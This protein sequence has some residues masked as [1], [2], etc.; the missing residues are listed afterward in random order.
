MRI[1]W[2]TNVLMPEALMYLKGQKTHKGSGGWMHGLSDELC[3]MDDIKLFIATIT[4]LVSHLTRIQGESMVHYAIPLCGNDIKY[5]KKYE[6]TY[7]KIYQEVK[8]D[9]VH[10]HG[11]E[12]P[13][14]LAALRACGAKH[15]VISIQGLVSSISSYYL[16]GISLKDIALNPTLHD[17]LRPGLLKQK[18]EMVRRGEYEVQLFKEAEN[19]IGRTDWD[20]SQLK[21]RAP[22]VSYYN[23]DEILRKTFYEGDTWVYSQ[24][25]P[26]S[27]FL[28]SGGY[29]LKGLHKVLEAIPLVKRVFPDV[30]VRVAGDD[31]TY[32]NCN[33]KKRIKISTYG[34]IIKKMINKY[35]ISSNVSFSGPLTAEEMKLEYLRANVFICPSSIENS[36][37]SLCEAQVLGVP[38]LA[39]YVGGTPDLMRN[40]EEHLYRFE[41]VEVMSEKICQIFAQKE[42]MPHLKEIRQQA[43]K[44][45]NTKT[46][47]NDILN[48][49]K[50]VMQERQIKN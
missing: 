50:D 49:Y 31:I 8:P 39:S 32:S 44:R 35:D 33:I 30:T 24:C 38:V 1:L 5:N 47:V 46:V 41:D 36:P 9:I 15:T 48:I 19:V 29:P 25:N 20:Y 4:P 37:N 3:K 11:T 10:I 26:H 17:I 12:Y 18:K 42:N 6:E 34:R 16:A 13:H 27:I 22:H 14:S 7:L 43:L 21:A 2:I 40:D 23:C 45:H 28:S